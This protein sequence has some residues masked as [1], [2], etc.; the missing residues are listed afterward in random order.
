M[1]KIHH[2][3]LEAMKRRGEEI[4]TETTQ[5]IPAQAIPQDTQV[6]VDKATLDRQNAIIESLAARLASVEQGTTPKA[7]ISKGK[8]VE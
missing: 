5:E 8:V 7:D 4:P 6:L 3:T 2:K 1:N